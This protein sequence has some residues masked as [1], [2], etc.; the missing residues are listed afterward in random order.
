MSVIGTD[1]GQAI[2][3]LGFKACAVFLLE[4]IAK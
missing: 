4:Q 1:S 3:S 2:S